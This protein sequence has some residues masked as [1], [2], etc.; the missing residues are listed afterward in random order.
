[1]R[2]KLTVAFRLAVSKLRVA[3]ALALL[4]ACGPFGSDDDHLRNVRVADV[5]IDPVTASPIVELVENGERGRRLGIW[6][7]EFEAESI[8]RA[9]EHQPSPRPN[10]HDLLKAVLDQIQGKVQ[11]IVVTELRGST[12]YAVIELELRGKSVSVDARPSDAIAVALRADAPVLVRE[13]LFQDTAIPDDEHALE[14]D[15]GAQPR[16]ESRVSAPL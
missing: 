5:R 2:R 10:P 8:A 7:G 12:Y 11:R 6:V 9:M 13:S 15:F 1:M 14:I 3:C 4:T 16:R